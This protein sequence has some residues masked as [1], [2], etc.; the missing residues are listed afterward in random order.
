M[1]LTHTNSK[2]SIS[3]TSSIGSRVL[4]PTWSKDSQSDDWGLPGF[5][6]LHP[7]SAKDKE[8]NNQVRFDDESP[9]IRNGDNLT[10]SFFGIHV[11]AEE[12]QKVEFKKSPSS[13]SLHNPE[14]SLGKSVMGSFK[15]FSGP[16]GA[17][18]EIYAD[19]VASGKHVKKVEDF[20]NRE[21]IP[22]Y[23]NTHTT[24]SVTG[25][26]STS[27][28][29][30]A[31]EIIANA[32]N[33]NS[34]QSV[35][36]AK[37]VNYMEDIVI[38]AGNGTTAAIHKLVGMLGL[39]CHLPSHYDESHR[40]IVFTSSYEHHSNLLSWRESSAEVVTVM[41]SPITGVC[42]KDLLRLLEKYSSRKMKIGSFSAASN[43]SGILTSTNEVSALMHKAGGLVFFDY[44]T[45]APYVTMN[46]NPIVTGPDA[47]YVYKDA[48]VF[49]GHKFV[50]G[51]G[52]PG[53]LVV[54]KDIIPDIPT[55]PGGGTVLVVT[56]HRQKYIE[57]IMEREESGTPNILGDIKMGL[58]MSI[59]QSFGALKKTD[60][61]IFTLA[62]LL[63]FSSSRSLPLLLNPPPPHP[64]LLLPTTVM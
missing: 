53:I 15:R 23:A 12:K 63:I 26:Q 11:E 56:E 47:P 59:K 5:L 40:P 64:L 44:A 41:Y 18:P 20:V 8:R 29:E 19:W 13:K 58:V 50:G 22:F 16:F 30:E 2:Y 25:N 6:P 48:I 35:R 51:P 37:N 55:I 42:L 24:T 62:D 27:Y 34:P 57:N 31:R 54:K 46:M 21:I 10:R 17:R 7:I 49:S 61:L 1:A 9:L 52:C 36:D 28:R 38:F 4:T 60:Y 3:G 14:E 43:V 39:K 32:V 33:A 45:A